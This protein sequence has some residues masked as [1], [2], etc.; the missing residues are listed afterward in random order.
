MR[1]VAI[2]ML[3]GLGLT[4]AALADNGVRP[5]RDD[6]QPAV[7]TQDH[8][9]EGGRRYPPPNTANL[10]QKD[11]RTSYDGPVTYRG[12]SNAPVPK[13]RSTNPEN[14]PPSQVGR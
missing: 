7:S 13:D 2:T 5:T 11:S 10:L 1:F 6:F 9:P 4:G 8:P 12:G 14:K 3:V